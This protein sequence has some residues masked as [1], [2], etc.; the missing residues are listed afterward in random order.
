MYTDCVMNVESGLLSGLSLVC[1][2]VAGGGG[3]G[4][5]IV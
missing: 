2:P 1:R 5:S 4:G 3:G